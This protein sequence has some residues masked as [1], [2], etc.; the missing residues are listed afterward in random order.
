M[1]A[2]EWRAVVGYEGKYEVSSQG[3]VRALYREQEF[4]A[5]WGVARMR[6][7]AKNCL[8]STS[9]NGYKYVT[10][11]KDASGRKHLVHRLVMAAFEGESQLQVNHKDGD[12][13]NNFFSNLEYCTSLQNLRHCI[14]VLG[15]KRGAGSGSAKVTEDE[16][17]AIR[18]DRRILRE[19][20][21]DYGITLQ[22]VHL[23]KKRKNWGHLE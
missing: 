11:S 10:L 16:V 14:D 13:T 7:P 15:K 17:R 21:A 6:F 19:I 3:A 8:L 22:A 1:N 12:K 20:A 5:R 23:I 2:E 4:M 18:E 9:T